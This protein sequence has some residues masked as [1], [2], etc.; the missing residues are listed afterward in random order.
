LF[1]EANCQNN[2]LYSF[3]HTLVNVHINAVIDAVM[4]MMMKC[5]AFLIQNQANFCCSV[6][7]WRNVNR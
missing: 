6:S 4:Y 5:Q 2:I 7:M 1:E 3:Q